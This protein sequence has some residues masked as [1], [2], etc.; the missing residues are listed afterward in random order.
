MAL[1][2]ASDSS[3]VEF[4]ATLDALGLAQ[5]RIARLFDVGARSV[6]RWRHGDRRVPRGVDIVLRLLAAGVI[7][8]DQVEQAAIPIP[9]RTNGHAGPE[10]PVFPFVEPVP[11]QAALT[12]VEATTVAN[13]NP[14]TA[15]KVFTLS[16]GACRWP[17]GD[18][19]RPD[20]RFCGNPTVAGPY[21][22]Q[23]CAAAYVHDASIRPVASKTHLA[24]AGKTKSPALFKGTNHAVAPITLS[25]PPAEAPNRRSVR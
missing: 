21:C 13:S 7:T 18:P 14:T 1:H 16:A 15:E 2:T 19:R 6:R 25:V 10:P 9:A 11:A 3:A 8:I 5:Y 23:H 17:Y 4:R 22:E 20:F 24:Y 12:R